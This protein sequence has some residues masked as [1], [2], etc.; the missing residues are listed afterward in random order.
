M[1][2]VGSLYNTK[3]TSLGELKAQV[4][5]TEN[6]GVFSELGSAQPNNVS[7]LNHSQVRGVTSYLLSLLRYEQLNFPAI[8]NTGKRILRLFVVCDI[9]D[10]VV[11]MTCQSLL[12]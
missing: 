4:L 10:V 1:H 8:A 3:L 11:L 5:R 7:P 2:L 12:V 6:I 9:A